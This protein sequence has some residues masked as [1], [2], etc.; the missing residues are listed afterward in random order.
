MFGS[1]LL[2]LGLGDSYQVYSGSG[3]ADIVMQSTRS[4]SAKAMLRQLTYW[5]TAL[6]D[7]G[8]GLSI[9]IVSQNT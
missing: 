1:F 2:S 4:T 7:T 8:I 9:G 3:G 5:T 6:P